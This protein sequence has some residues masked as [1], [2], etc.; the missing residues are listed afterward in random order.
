MEKQ[1]DRF[2]RIKQYI[3]N[4]SWLTFSVLSYI[5][6]SSSGGSH[7]LLVFWVPEDWVMDENKK[8]F[9][10]KRF[11]MGSL[12]D[13]YLKGSTGGHCHASFLSA[14][15]WIQLSLRYR[16]DQC[17]NPR[18]HSGSSSLSASHTHCDKVKGF[19]KTRLIQCN[20]TKWI[21]GHLLGIKQNTLCWLL[22]RLQ[23]FVI[24]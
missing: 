16:R 11:T 24:W 13:R 20:W 5:P 17:N 14:N 12:S 1:Q 6:Q 21:I 4:T 7:F 15:E 18:A 23:L 22:Q 3:K 19:G 9:D 2:L 10:G 8:H